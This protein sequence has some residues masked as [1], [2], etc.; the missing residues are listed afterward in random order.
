MG[1]QD[2]AMTQFSDLFAKDFETYMGNNKQVD[3][4]LLIGIEF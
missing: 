2:F 1:N 3:D 4:L